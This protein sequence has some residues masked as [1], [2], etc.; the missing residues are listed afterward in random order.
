MTN[1]LLWFVHSLIINLIGLACNTI[2]YI[3]KLWRLVEWGKKN[4]KIDEE[5]DEECVKE[6]F[7]LNRG[8]IDRDDERFRE[9]VGKGYCSIN[10]WDGSEMKLAWSRENSS[11]FPIF[12]LSGNSN[13]S[14][15][16]VCNI[17]RWAYFLVMKTSS[18][19]FRGTL[20]WIWGIGE[21]VL[22]YNLYPIYILFLLTNLILIRSFSLLSSSNDAS[23]DI[24]DEENSFEFSPKAEITSTL[25]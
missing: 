5:H 1:K 7:Q 17:L 8:E 20:C 9:I 3:Q 24:V 6:G 13:T 2:C 22:E 25:H 10:I 23:V 12:L 21:V 18:N 4:G 15:F 14:I 19:I 16:K 11:Y